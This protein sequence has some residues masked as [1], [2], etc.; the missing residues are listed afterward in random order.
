MSVCPSWRR[1]RDLLSSL[2]PRYQLLRR[3]LENNFSKICLPP[4]KLRL[5]CVHRH[6][7]FLKNL[8]SN[9]ISYQDN[10]VITEEN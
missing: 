1:L 4:S 5:N 7:S 8:L 6:P 9:Y 3:M 10:I 2:L